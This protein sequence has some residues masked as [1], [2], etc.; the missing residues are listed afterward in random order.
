MLRVA[1]CWHVQNA[2]HVGYTTLLHDAY[3]DLDVKVCELDVKV[4]DTDLAH[5]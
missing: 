1:T 4:C 3:V 5:S 2:K